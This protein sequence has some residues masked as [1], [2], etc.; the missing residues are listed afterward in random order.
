MLVYIGTFTERAPNGHP[1]GGAPSKGVYLMR[2]DA[3]DGRLGTPTL[4][5]PV[6]NPSFLA[7]SPDHRFLYAMSET[8]PESFVTAYAIDAESGA[9]HMLNRLPTGGSGTA[10][11]AL[12]R[13]G[14]NL[15]MANYGSGSISVIQVEPDGSLGRLTSFVQ[16]TALRGTAGAGVTPHPH[17]MVAS[18]ENHF[19]IDPDLGLNKIFIYGFDA[20]TGTLHLPAALVDLPPEEGPRHFVFSRD[21]RFGYLIAQA[22]GHVLVF[23]WNESEGKLTPVEVAASMP[24][25]LDATNMS[26]EI[27]LTPD[28]RLLYESNRRTHGPGRELG[29]DSIVGY[30]VNPETGKLT[31][32]EDLA[33][34]GEIPRCFS[35]DPTGKYL[36]LAAQQENRVDVYRINR[37]TGKLAKTGQSGYI[38]TPACMQIVPSR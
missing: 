10:Y 21:G 29:P 9:L 25:G 31:E 4:A 17:A 32:V 23:S 18:P 26:G 37:R 15:M 36:L 30:R 12:D 33:L 19:I 35:I 7:A 11:I 34:G 2:F 38:H 20:A 6:E 22:T 14:R 8:A 5:A 27:E 3:S 1:D 13:T 28:S 24:P 16:H